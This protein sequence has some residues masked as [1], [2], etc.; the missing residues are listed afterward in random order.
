LCPRRDYLPAKF[1]VFTFARSMRVPLV[2]AI[3][4]SLGSQAT[5][6]T[7]AIMRRAWIHDPTCKVSGEK[8][9]ETSKWS[10]IFVM[11]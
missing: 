11:E 4:L 10:L 7:A 6:S 8:E 3:L 1:V 9:R 5:M 2:G